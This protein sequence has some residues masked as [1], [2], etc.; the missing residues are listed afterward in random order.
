MSRLAMQYG[1]SGI[2]LAKICKRLD[3]PY[4]PRG[5]WAK[6]A[7]GK[8]V[9]VTSL[10]VL[11]DS[12]PKQA[13]IRPTPSKPN[14]PLLTPE[15]KEKVAAARKGAALIN[16]PERLV[17]PHRIIANWLAD[18]KHQKQRAQLERNPLHR[19]LAMPE[20]FTASDHRRHR[21]LNALLKTLERHGGE[22]EQGEKNK[23]FVKLDGERI[24]FQ[25]RDKFKKVRRSLT[26]EEKRW[27]FASD[28]DWKQELQP[29]GKLIFCIK[30]RLP[31]RLRSEWLESDENPIEQHLPEII[32][33]LIAAG[34]LLADETRRRHEAEQKFRLAEQRRYE[35]Q[36]LRKRDE[37]RWQR[38]VEIA[39]QWQSIET[40][41]KFLG[42]FRQQGVDLDDEIG[43]QPLREWVAWAE[44]KLESENPLLK[45]ARGIFDSVASASEKTRNSER[46]GVW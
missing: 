21:V 24:E 2:A 28:K 18:H 34:P 42:S 29:T 13:L 14:P 7:A 11:K 19:R 8:K 31:A 26:D 33:T 32:A 46:S 17:R 3:I 39:H 41:R 38:F 25:L 22:I 30:T 15:F 5:Y 35:E 23:L 27:R 1:I 20:P 9:T 36:Q 12:T 10:P 45:G 44:K 37:N 40:A 43:G 4:P 16:V 6:K